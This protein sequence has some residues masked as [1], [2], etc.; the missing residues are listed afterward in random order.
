MRGMKLI[1]S[2]GMTK[3]QA[4]FLGADLNKDFP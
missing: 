2:A 1:A 3:V 4:A